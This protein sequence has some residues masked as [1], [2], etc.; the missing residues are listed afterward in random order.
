MVLATYLAI[1]HTPGLSAVQLHRQLGLGN[2]TAWA[3]LQRMKLDVLPKGVL[4]VSEL[5][6]VLREVRGGD[7]VPYQEIVIPDPLRLVSGRIAGL[8]PPSPRP[9]MGFVFPS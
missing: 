8:G 3:L 5:R 9:R 2:E 1:T 4:D 6:R 7:A